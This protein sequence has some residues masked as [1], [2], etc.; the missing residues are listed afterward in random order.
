MAIS[1]QP[2]SPP[3]DPKELPLYLQQELA[4]MKASQ[5]GAR[6]SIRLVVTNIQPIRFSDGDIYEADGVNWNPGAGPGLYI[7]R[8]GAWVL[9][10]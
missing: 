2:A 7:R 10:G 8:A 4:R 6:A 9:L 3:S 1:Y 5:E